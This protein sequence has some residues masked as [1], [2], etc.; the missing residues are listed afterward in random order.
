MIVSKISE[1][2]RRQP[3]WYLVVAGIIVIAAGWAVFHF[4]TR[5]ATPAS[6]QVSGVS[7]VHIASVASLSSEA[8][9]LPVTGDVTSLHQATILAQSSGEVVSLSRALGDRVGAG[10]VIAQFENSSQRAAVL[11]AQ[12]AYDGA[13]AALAKTEGTGAANSGIASAQAVSSAANAQ[14]SLASALLSSYA[15][16]DDAVHT[17]SDALFNN[18]RSGSPTLRSFTIPDSQLVINVQSG[19]AAVESVLGDAESISKTSVSGA[20]A[21]AVVLKMST[22]MQQVQSFLNDLIK[23]VN[24]AVPNESVGAPAIAADQAALSAARTEVVNALTGLTS[25]KNAYDAAASGAQTAA[26]SASSGTEND[27]AAAQANVKSALGALNAAQA[28]L[29]KTVVRSPISGLIVSLPVRQGDYVSAFSPV[30]SVSN[31]GALQIEAYVTPDDA[32]TLTIGGKARIDD[33]ADGVIVFVAPAID[34]SNGKIQVKIGISGS[35]DALTDGETVSVSLS[36]SASSSS[37]NGATSAPGNPVIPIIAAKITPEGPVIFTVESS[38]LVSHP[39]TLGIILGDRV[40]V[41]SGLSPE[42][43]IVTDA[44]GLSNG[45]TVVVDE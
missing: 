5:T 34:P 3:R 4:S 6:E 24:Q 20:N 19:R 28:N 17:K 15:A 30:A 35:A 32:K 26:N 8:G 27:I 12:G 10:E 41:V 23:A 2:L 13:R 29:E 14:T 43:A 38:A 22:D 1:Y 7:H 42:M 11:Q 37:A 39:I 16:L 33:V 44:R 31:P 9:P 45:Q 36:R 18:S 40:T 25:A 21:D